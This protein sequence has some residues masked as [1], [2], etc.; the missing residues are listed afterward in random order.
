MT[1]ETQDNLGVQ[2]TASALQ[3]L[4]HNAKRD[5]EW[6]S[7]RQWGKRASRKENK[8]G[9]H[10]VTVILRHK[11]SLGYG[12]LMTHESS[13]SVI[14]LQYDPVISLKAA[15]VHTWHICSFIIGP[16]TSHTI[17]STFESHQ[18]NSKSRAGHFG[19]YHEKASVF[20]ALE[21][22]LWRS[23]SR[24]LTAQISSFSWL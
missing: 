19:S 3:V 22:T 8:W 18:G 14:M 7:W 17:I 9:Q 24:G 10:L 5:K 20:P 2:P 16:S 23:P 6:Q 12:T 1:H 15:V 13:I 11:Y 4:C 21:R